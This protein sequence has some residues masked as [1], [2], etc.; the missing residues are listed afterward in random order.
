MNR[1]RHSENHVS[2]SAA[3]RSFVVPPRLGLRAPTP[4]GDLKRRGHP[5]FG[6]VVEGVDSVELV[7]AECAGSEQLGVEA[8][9]VEPQPSA[10]SVQVGEIGVELP[11]N[12]VQPVRVKVFDERSPAMPI[13]RG[14]VLEKRPVHRGDGVLTVVRMGGPRGQ[15]VPKHVE[16]FKHGPAAGAQRSHHASN[17]SCRVGQVLQQATGMDQVEGM[18]GQFGGGDVEALDGKGG[19]GE[20]VEQCG[21][22]VDGVD[23]ASGCDRV[24]EPRGDRAGTRADL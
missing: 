12:T 14:Q 16:G 19:S 22:K 17:C 6:L 23:R 18:G 24:G 20:L 3:T 2:A 1:I 9:D 13:H 21:V 11:A 10:R 5:C 15:L 7:D 4:D 8:F